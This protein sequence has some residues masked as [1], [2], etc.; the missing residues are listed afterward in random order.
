M[1]YTQRFRVRILHPSTKK[2]IK[3]EI[4]RSFKMVLKDI[5]KGTIPILVREMMPTTRFM[6][7]IKE[8][9]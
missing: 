5:L 8:V 2:K 4:A 9:W 7:T 6:A 1:H 3:L